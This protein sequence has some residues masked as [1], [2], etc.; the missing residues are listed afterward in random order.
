MIKTII[1]CLGSSIVGWFLSCLAVMWHKYHAC[2]K[3]LKP[4]VFLRKNK[5]MALALYALLGI[6]AGI[7]FAKYEYMPSKCIRYM[8]LICGL[9]IIAYIDKKEQIIPNFIL[10][11]LLGV[12]SILLVVDIL[13]YTDVWDVILLNTLGGLVLGFIIFL[14]AYLLSRKGIGL[15]DVKLVAVMG[16]YL[17]A[18]ALYGAIVLS[19]LSCVLYTGFQ[20]LRKKLKLRDAVAF[21]PFLAIGTI[22]GILIGI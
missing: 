5:L 1:L 14:I 21:G 12:R 10:V 15:G 8:I 11:I 19:L 22:L 18:S 2:K 9:C 13:L 7:L 3:F 20:M 6:V 17:G 4:S 16:F